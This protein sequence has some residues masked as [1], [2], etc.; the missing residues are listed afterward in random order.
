MKNYLS[1]AET[2]KMIRSVLKESFPGVKFSVVSSTY[3]M[4]A[5]ITI[6][7]N[8]GPNADAVKAAVGIF[9]GSYFDGM[10]DYKGQRYAA[11][12]GQEMSFGADYVFVNRYVSDAA[13][14][15]AI[16]ALY[17][18]FAGNFRNDPLP[19][20]TV[21]DYNQGRLFGRN[22]PGMG[23][24][25]ANEFVRQIGIVIQD[26]NAGFAVQPSATLA[27]ITSLGDDGYGQGCVGRLAA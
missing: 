3:S 24:G 6:K 25:L 18:K 15:Q 14:A 2:A 9:E 12:D 23:N 21:E 8:D 17:E 19:K 11:I 5:S 20:A 27:R 1:C 4:G 10:Q 16:D 26:T 22:I 7:Y 13:M